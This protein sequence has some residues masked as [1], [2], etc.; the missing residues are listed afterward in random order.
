MMRL[1]GADCDGKITTWNP[2][3]ERLFGYS[4]E[5]AIDRR[6]DIIIPE[7]RSEEVSRITESMRRGKPVEHYETQ[8]QHKDGTGWM[9]P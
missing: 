7:D 1:S 9:S 3:A 8:L 4:A 2:A 6:I 5:E